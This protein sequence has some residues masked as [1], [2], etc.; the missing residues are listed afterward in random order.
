MKRASYRLAAVKRT[1]GCRAYSVRRYES[2]WGHV[3]TRG[4]GLWSYA[5]TGADDCGQW[6]TTRQGAIEALLGVAL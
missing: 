4:R 1:D 6:F 3:F 2:I 5:E